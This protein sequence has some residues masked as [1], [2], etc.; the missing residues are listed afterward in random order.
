MRRL[1]AVCFAVTST[2]T[3]H[4]CRAD[5]PH[6]GKP[7]GNATTAVSA[8]SA[9]TTIRRCNSYRPNHAV[10]NRPTGQGGKDEASK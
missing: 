1:F 9:T 7:S 3:R 10:E 4:F 6:G 5:G 2:G 8:L